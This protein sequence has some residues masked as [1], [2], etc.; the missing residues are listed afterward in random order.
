MQIMKLPLMV[1]ALIIISFF[2][3]LILMPQ[4]VV[5]ATQDLEIRLEDGVLQYKT[6]TSDWIELLD[7]DELKGDAGLNVQDIIINNDSEF[8]FIMSD[9]SEINAGALDLEFPELDILESLE[10]NSNGELT[11]ES[12]E[13]LVNL[14]SILGQ[15]GPMGVTGVGIST[16][17]I[18]TEGELIVVYTDD[19]FE[20]LGLVVGVDGK[21]GD[22]G[23]DGLTPYIGDNGNWWI[24][25]TDTQIFVEN[26][27]FYIETFED[28]AQISECMTCDYKLM[29]DIFISSQSWDPIGLDSQTVFTGTFD[30]NNNVI[31]NLNGGLFYGLGEDAKILNLGMF[32]ND[33]ADTREGEGL[34]A[35]VLE[36]EVLIQNVTFDMDTPFVLATGSGLIAGSLDDAKVS[37]DNVRVYYYEPVTMMAS[38]GLIFG[39][40]TD[41]YLQIKNLSVAGNPSVITQSDQTGFLMGYGDYLDIYIQDSYF[42]IQSVLEADY[43]GGL[44]GRLDHSEF[45][46]MDL[47]VIG[48]IR[49]NNHSFVGGLIG[50]SQDSE[51]RLL[52]TIIGSDGFTYRFNMSIE[53]GLS[54]IGGFAG[55]LQNAEVQVE[56]ISVVFHHFGSGSYVG[57]LV[58]KMVT[59]YD[60]DFT[61]FVLKN[62]SF[63]VEVGSKGD[64]NGGIIGLAHIND[65]E[66][67]QV[68]MTFNA[69]SNTGFGSFLGGMIGFVTIQEI[70]NSETINLG[71]TY[72]LIRN[73]NVRLL[74][75]RGGSSMGGFIGG[76][77][78]IEK[79]SDAPGDFVSTYLNNDG[80]VVSSGDLIIDNNQITG[81]LSSSVSTQ[82]CGGYLGRIEGGTLRFTY[83]EALLDLSSCQDT[84]GVGFVVGSLDHLDIAEMRYN[85]LRGSYYA[86]ELEGNF[87]GGAITGYISSLVSGVISNNSVFVSDRNNAPSSGDYFIGLDDSTNA[88]DI[89]NNILSFSAD[90]ME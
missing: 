74:D 20:N 67:N 83:N 34:L 66:I 77:L 72:T 60:T 49:A 51:F 68:D 75:V 59:D 56:E 25:E 70:V 7:M 85:V 30:G 38:T 3:A 86:S 29:E 88:L 27:V 64:Y 40:G 37:L 69:Y 21:D 23:E 18:N 19:T 81:A 16:A 12:S 14:G 76:Y 43:F 35:H 46:T 55:Y 44:I 78:N 42:R 13:G 58:G 24:G 89:F 54:S 11:F 32:Y 47:V 10:I 15:E 50:Y 41:S 9:N 17:R 48:D 73:S 61:Q 84:Q 1:G 2:T 62:G 87:V 90:L 71:N 22:D 53:N 39:T 33:N 52:D 31:I 6:P 82:F 65:L 26:P 8:V 45:E 80:N 36:D 63:N 79:A 28:L 57:G 4:E 5:E